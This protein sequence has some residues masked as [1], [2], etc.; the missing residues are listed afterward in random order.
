MPF[1]KG[2]QSGSKSRQCGENSHVLQSD[3]TRIALQGSEL[4][5]CVVKILLHVKEQHIDSPSVA[6]NVGD[7]EWTVVCVL[8][9]GCYSPER[10]HRKSGS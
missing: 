1:A 5:R 7:D 6:E 2:I 8:F 3:L 9:E 4:L 10:R